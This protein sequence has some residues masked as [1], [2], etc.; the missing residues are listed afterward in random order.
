[1]RVELP[2]QGRVEKRMP[3]CVPLGDQY[4][5]GGKRGRDGGDRHT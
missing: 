2:I 3:I 5:T 4:G 1:M